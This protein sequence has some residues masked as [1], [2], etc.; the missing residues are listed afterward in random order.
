MSD[1]NATSL[2]DLILQLGF[3][4][5]DEKSYIATDLNVSMVAALF[6]GMYT[7]IFVGTMYAY[8][9]R[10]VSGRYFVPVTIST[11]YLCNV[12]YFGLEW[13]DTKW[14]FIDNGESRDTIFF[15]FLVTPAKIHTPGNIVNTV[16]L[17]LSDVLLIWRCFN[18][19]DCSYRVIAIPVLL[20]ITET[21]LMLTQ[22]IGI[23]IIS[24][25]DKEKRLNILNNIAAAGI[26]VTA[27]T[28]IITT[29]LIAYRVNTFLRNTEISPKKFRH[30]VDIVVQSAAVYSALL[31]VS[32]VSM[33]ISL[34]NGADVRL[35]NFELWA[36]VLALSSAGISTTIMVARV[37]MLT[38]TSNPPTSLHLTGIQFQPQSTAHTGTSDRVSVNFHAYNEADRDSASKDG[39]TR[40]SKSEEKA[41]HDGRV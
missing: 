23:A 10:G 40:E 11:L 4:V 9:S 21:A 8:M 20:T 24:S 22:A 35:L 27:C 29:M 6:M 15:S 31:L 41:A 19:W 14:Q 7:I 32:G 13:Y 34:P 16:I 26:M 3:T 28:N 37:A 39:H 5:N 12:A 36:S 38:D 18:L 17:V 1:S 30:I 33:I 2:H 25:T